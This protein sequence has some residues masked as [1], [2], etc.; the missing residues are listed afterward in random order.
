MRLAKAGKRAR[1]GRV[2]ARARAAHC[3]TQGGGSGRRGARSVR[4]FGGSSPRRGER[5]DLE[6][7]RATAAPT[8]APLQR[9]PGRGRLA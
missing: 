3:A 1:L 2:C 5:S 4:G 9:D 6:R 8:Q 7:S